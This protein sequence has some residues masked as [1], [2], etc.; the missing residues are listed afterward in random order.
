M[1]I[2][3]NKKSDEEKIVEIN[4][5]RNELRKFTNDEFLKIT[6]GINKYSSIILKNIINKTKEPN[7]IFDIAASILVNIVSNEIVKMYIFLYN[8]EDEPSLFYLL[9]EKII[10]EIIP[11]FIKS[12]KDSIRDNLKKRIVDIQS[13]AN[14]K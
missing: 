14:K 7:E 11:S 13:E 1:K 5:K 3:V 12:L 2:D 6:D 8:I 4:L 10:H 9:N